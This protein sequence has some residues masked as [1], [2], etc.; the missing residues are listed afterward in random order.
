MISFCIPRSCYLVCIPF[1]FLS[2]FCNTFSL[3]RNSLSIDYSVIFSRLLHFCFAIRSC[4][5][6]FNV[7]FFTF[8]FR[9][10]RNLS[11][12]SSLVYLILCSPNF[13]PF[14]YLFYP[15]LRNENYDITRVDLAPKSRFIFLASANWISFFLF[16]RSRLRIRGETKTLELP[17][18]GVWL[19][20][21][22]VYSNIIK[23][24]A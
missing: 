8:A 13:P 24:L 17:Y 18:V 4:R 5:S 14:S 2:C 9:H 10:F 7:E 6:C 11:C 22:H 20:C 21:I 3:F 19:P 23:L 12:Q 1:R 16:L 15:S